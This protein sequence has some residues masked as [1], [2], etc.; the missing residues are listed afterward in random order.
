MLA[1]K[2]RP[3]CIFSQALCSR[4]T[5]IM[6]FKLARVTHKQGLGNSV[7]ITPY[8]G[9]AQGH[10]HGPQTTRSLWK[11]AALPEDF[12]E[13]ERQKQEAQK[14]TGKAW[15]SFVLFFFVFLRMDPINLHWP[16]L[17]LASAVFKAINSYTLSKHV[18]LSRDKQLCVKQ[19][20]TIIYSVLAEN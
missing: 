11:C 3:A 4:P 19:L 13:Q 10:R 20:Y 17:N 6:C 18:T 8:R 9:N 14:R 2:T 15:N 7:V 16:D 1:R 12:I 5:E